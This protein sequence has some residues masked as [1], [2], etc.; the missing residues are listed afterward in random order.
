[1][2]AGT[3]VVDLDVREQLLTKGFTIFEPTACGK[4][5]FQRMKEALGDR[6]VVAVP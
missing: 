1:M 6:I 5:N 4:L 2:S 3:V